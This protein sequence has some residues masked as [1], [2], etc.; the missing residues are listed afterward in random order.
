MLVRLTTITTK[1][2]EGVKYV[3][4]EEGYMSRVTLPH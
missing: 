4:L 2:R 1:G 3:L